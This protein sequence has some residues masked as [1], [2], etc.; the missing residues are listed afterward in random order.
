[1]VTQAGDYQFW[2]NSEAIRVTVGAVQI[3]VGIAQRGNLDKRAQFFNGTQLTGKE[4]LWRV[5]AAL[6][7]NVEITGQA[8]IRDDLGGLWIV[9]TAVLVGTGDDPG[10]WECLTVKGK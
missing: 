7:E 8:K 5:P 9:K 1:V 4:T 3:D 10:H 2:D 6:M